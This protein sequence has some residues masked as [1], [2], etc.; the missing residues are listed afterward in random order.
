[1]ARS[2][3]LLALDPAS[4]VALFVGGESCSGDESDSDVDSQPDVKRQRLEQQQQDAAEAIQQA[5]AAAGAM[6]T[7]VAE[8]AG[9]VDDS[10][11]AA[12]AAAHVLPSAVPLTAEQQVAVL[13]QFPGLSPEAL[14][15]A[16]A[17]L[18]TGPDGQPLPLTLPLIGPG[19]ESL[20]SLVLDPSV[21][22]STQLVG[23]QITGP[24]GE[25][26]THEQVMRRESNGQTGGAVHSASLPGGRPGGGGLTGQASEESIVPYVATSCPCCPCC[27]TLRLCWAGKPAHPHSWHSIPDTPTPSCPSAAGCPAGLCRANAVHHPSGAR[28]DAASCCA[29]VCRPLPAPQGLV[30]CSRG[31]GGRTA[32]LAHL[33]TPCCP[34]CGRAGSAPSFIIWG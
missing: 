28:P 23:T 14:A 18:P 8:V 4:W 11:A 9:V 31:E 27:C 13:Q 2:A 29:A 3:D 1:M 15:A 7:H 19:G 25:E 16:Q 30:G 21:L 24:N 34:G 20:P 17:A 10:A 26:L 6:Q 32:A 12:A 5:P 33:T 22:F